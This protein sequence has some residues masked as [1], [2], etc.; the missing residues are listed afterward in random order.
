MKAIDV[1]VPVYDAYDQTVRSLRSLLAS[2]NRTDSEIVVVYDA[3]PD[4]TLKRYI[5]ELAVA[6]VLTLLENEHN[7]GFV[8]SVNRGMALHPDRDVVLLNSDTEVANDWL[9]R[10]VAC[11]DSDETIATVTPFSN[12]AEICSFP[13][14][15]SVN[16]LPAGWSTAALDAAF[17][18]GVSPAAIDLPTG[19]GFCLFIRRR[20]L[21]EVGGFNEKLFGRG[22]GEENDF[23]RRVARRGWRNVLC[24]NI[25]VY[26]EGGASFGEEKQARIA[27]AMRILDKLYPDYH[28]LVHGF[29]R[30]DPPR[31]YRQ[32]AALAAMDPDKPR[33][34]M[35]THNLGGGTLR[36]VKELASHI[37]GQA[38][39]FILRL[40]A[41]GHFSIKA[42]LELAD[43]EL[44][45]Q[46]P[47]QQALFYQSCQQLGIDRVHIHHVKGFEGVI[48]GLLKRLALPY[49]VTLHDYYLI[50]GNPT[51][52]DK[53]GLFCADKSRRDAV[54]GKQSPVPLGLSAEQWRAG[55]AKLLARAER[56]FAPSHYA[57]ALHADYF[58]ELHI[59]VRPH[60]DWEREAPYPSVKWQ[61][62]LPERPLIVGVL[63][64]LGLE[65]GADILEKTALLAKKRKC[66]IEF[67]LIGYA[68]R[69]LRGVVEHGAYQDAELSAILRRVNPNCVWFPCQWPETYSYTLSACLREGLPVLAPAFGA[70]VERLQGRPAS[71]LQPAPASP[72]RWLE[73]LLDIEQRLRLTA[74]TELHWSQPEAPAGPHGYKVNY[75]AAGRAPLPPT[76]QQDLLD[77]LAQT[78]MPVA[79]PE[80][81]AKKERLLR[82][83]IKT[84]AVPGF[85]WLARSVPFS[86]QRRL[87]R[88]L[89]D[90]A[91]HE[92]V[93]EP[94][95][96]TRKITNAR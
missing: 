41:P 49:D 32:Q 11:A 71:W 2:A 36:H 21:D 33:I 20:A 30:T 44:T 65:K 69:K 85:L 34:L 60:P 16:A 72:E 28:G 66:R 80:S 92:M 35:V 1:I 46:W 94:H 81:I 96:D 17:A 38:Y 6:G 23:C 83:L 45:Y 61:H 15:C 91:L 89:S 67:H 74:S 86:W 12:N 5:T 29:I 84:R 59:T 93:D 55:A 56:V 51:L 53:F 54:C 39:V 14:M 64:A 82:L 25:F 24:T 31:I 90:K 73:C 19:V 58:P 76:T 70:F 87:K 13:A 78:G 57:A 7:L 18:A 63:G 77:L 42:E 10:L 22:Y 50:N 79:L 68:Y 27:D 8:G 48:L 95:P 37:A 43:V 47:E 40:S 52:A 3:G 26:H 4:E 9:D 88:L 75:V 62:L